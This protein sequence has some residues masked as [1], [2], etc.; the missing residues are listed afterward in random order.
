[1][2]RYCSDCRWCEPNGSPHYDKCNAPQNIEREDGLDLV[3]PR[4][5][6]ARRNWAWC[7]DHREDNLFQAIFGGTCGRRGRWFEPRPKTG[8]E[9]W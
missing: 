1:M 4:P 9:T 5:P 2:T 6:L 3:R 8:T 7:H